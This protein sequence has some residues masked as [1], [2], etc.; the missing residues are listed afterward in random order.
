MNRPLASPDRAGASGRITPRQNFRALNLL[1]VVTPQRSP[2]AGSRSVSGVA[3]AVLI[4]TVWA[5]SARVACALFS[6]PAPDQRKR[7]R[8]T[9]GLLKR[10][11]RVEDKLRHMCVKLI[12]SDQ[13]QARPG[14]PGDVRSWYNGRAA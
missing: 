2:N 11:P 4:R 3:C 1:L 14:R 6:L 7:R 9:T 8:R 5:D 10:S 13:K 12:P